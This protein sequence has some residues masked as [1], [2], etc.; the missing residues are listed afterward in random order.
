M[1]SAVTATVLATSTFL[2][3]PRMNRRT[4]SAKPGGRDDPRPDLRGDIAVT[5]DRP[6]DRVREKRHVE[7]EVEGLAGFARLAG[8]HRSR[9][10]M[11]GT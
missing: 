4:P 2:A 3:R 1:A 6:G 7:R 9:T 5:D 10:T 11:H 8:R